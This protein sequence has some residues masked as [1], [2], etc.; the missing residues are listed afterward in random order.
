MLVLVGAFLP[1]WPRPK[2]DA[3]F[4]LLVFMI[5]FI[6]I[7]HPHL[8]AGLQ[9]EDQAVRKGEALRVYCQQVVLKSGCSGSKSVLARR[10]CRI[11][12]NTWTDAWMMLAQCVPCMLVLGWR[13]HARAKLYHISANPTLGTELASSLKRI[14]CKTMHA[15]RCNRLSVGIDSDRGWLKR[16]NAVFI[17]HALSRIM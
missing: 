3:E 9:K 7:K 13:A 2:S 5:R 6:S 1:Q 10:L 8:E 11:T 17:L 16:L 12:N 14:A 4:L 15:S